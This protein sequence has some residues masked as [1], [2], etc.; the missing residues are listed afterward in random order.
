[1]KKKIF[2]LVLALALVLP[3]VSAF[4]TAAVGYGEAIDT[5]MI[6]LPNHVY[7]DDCDPY[8]NN[9]GEEREI[10]HDYT[11][12]QNSEYLHWYNCA[13]CGT[14]D[15]TSYALHLYDNDCDPTCNVCQRE[16]TIQHN[17]S[18]WDT[19]PLSHS[20]KCSVCGT[21]DEATRAP[22][23]YDNACDTDCNECAFLRAT[24]HDYSVQTGDENAHWMKCSV[25][26]GADDSTRAPHVYD[27]A[28]DTDCNT[29]GIPRLTT[30]D[31]SVQDWNDE[32]HWIK[33]SVCGTADDSTLA[34]HSYTDGKDT[35]CGACGYERTL[36]Y[37]TGDVDGDSDVDLDDAIY[38]LYHVNFKDTYPVNQSVDFDGSG[39][40][41]L[42]D[43]I[44]L[45]YHVN[46]KETYPLH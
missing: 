27:N 44:Y 39:T 25:C 46:F 12:L 36:L 5:P 1:M 9:C 6:P 21:A 30:H 34:V 45:L 20:K 16:R 43:A 28:C 14:T 13:V 37:T 38:L 41:D 7:T 8:C 19:D 15:D 18:A 33:C 17:Y 22:H 23:V 32:L 31:F 26:G 42:D 24:T 10:T 4:N 40:A 3:L 35:T 2:S 29:C 11:A